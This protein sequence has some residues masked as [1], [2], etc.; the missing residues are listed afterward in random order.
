MG[1]RKNIDTVEVHSGLY[2]KR[3]DEDAS[4]QCY[5]RMD[6]QQFRRSTKTTELADAK[7]MAL[8]WFNEARN[9][10][11]AGMSIERVSFEKLSDL[12]LAHI[13]GVGKYSYHSETIERH[14]L[15]FFRS[16]KDVSQLSTADFQDYVIFRRAKGSA[17]PQTLNRE[18]TVL[19]QIFD[20]ADKRGLL[21]KPIVI[22][23]LNERLTRRRR[24]HFTVEEYIKLCHAAQ[25]RIQEFDVLGKPIGSLV[26]QQRQL[27]FDYIKFM[28]NSGLRVD[29]AK[30]L[31]WRNVDFDNRAVLVQYSGKTKKPRKAFVRYT[32]LLALQRILARRTAYLAEHDGG[33]IDPN[34]RVFSLDNGTPVDNFKKGFNALLVAAGFVYTDIRDKHALYSLRHSYG[35]FR[36]TTK[37]DKRA[38]SKSLALQMGTS[39]RMIEKYYGHDEIHDYEDEL[40]GEAEPM[41]DR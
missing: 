12:Y 1:R 22:D 35:T 20:F 30:T 31:T 8:Q 38:S 11:T 39:V 7:L 24:P 13:E 28:T 4:W 6:A 17:L 5:F 29:E 16:F 3:Q 9:K 23:H 37:R 19:R 32:G 27:L 18:N 41:H 10:Q 2:L 21:S 36:L 14:F 34:E 40:A 33:P 15:P 26:R 25:S